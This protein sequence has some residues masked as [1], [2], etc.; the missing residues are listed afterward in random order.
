MEEKSCLPIADGK[1]NWV[2]LHGGLFGNSYQNLKRMHVLFQQF[3][4]YAFI[5]QIFTDMAEDTDYKDVHCN[6]RD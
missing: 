2:P 3:H 5:L 1:V 6:V 4:F